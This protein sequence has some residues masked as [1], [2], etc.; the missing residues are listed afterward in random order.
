M[1]S[2]QRPGEIT[3]YEELGVESTASADEIRDAFRALARLLHPDAQTDPQLKDMAEHQMR[4]LNRIHAVLSDP[5]RR[6]GYDDSLRSSRHAPIIVFSGSDGN[7]KKLLVQMS[8]AAVIVL[9]TIL[10]IW[11]AV[12]SNNT[13]EARG[14]EARAAAA[15]RS[16]DAGDGEAG[17]QISQLRARIRT[18]ETERNSALTQLSRLGGKLPDVANAGKSPAPAAA[19]ALTDL[20]DAA[21]PA[22]VHAV[23]APAAG[24]PQP[25]PVESAISASQYSGLWVYAKSTGSASP[26][27]KAQYLPEFIEVTMT[28]QNGSLH[29]QYHSRYQVLDH[30]V[31]PDVDFVFSGVPNGPL[32]NCAWQGPGGARGR[33]TMR[34]APVGEVEVSWNATEPG[35]QQWLVNGTAILTKK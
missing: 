35:T 3:Y 21:K 34:L 20:A 12:D 25:P 1:A 5:A 18:L 13:S 33:L 27:G 6:T 10:L 8:A 32:L 30:A 9:G 16:S 17:D 14:Q 29:G 19:T 7:L 22:A 31:S 24:A 2:S 15:T 11:F 23:S 26:G 4:K 28:A